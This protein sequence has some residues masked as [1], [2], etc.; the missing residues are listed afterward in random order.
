MIGGDGVQTPRKVRIDIEAAEPRIGPRVPLSTG[1][2][3]Q[4][5]DLL[6]QRKKKT[7]TVVATVEAG[8]PV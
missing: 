8:I 4:K 7:V 1:V 3:G 6:V 5:V 2:M